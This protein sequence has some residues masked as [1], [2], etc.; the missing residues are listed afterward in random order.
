VYIFRNLP[1]DAL[2]F[3]QLFFLHVPP[4]TLGV[5]LGTTHARGEVLE[6][7]HVQ[8]AATITRRQNAIT[9]L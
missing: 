4:R 9:S 1:L 8:T 2:S 3:S 7:I 6:A 5:L